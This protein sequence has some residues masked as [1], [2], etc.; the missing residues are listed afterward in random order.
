MEVTIFYSWQSDLPGSTNRSFIEKALKQAIQAIKSENILT[1]ELVMDRDTA[2]V[3]GSPPIADTIFAKIEQAG[4]FVCDVTTINDG[5]PTR[6]TPNPNVLVELGFALKVLGSSRIIMV[7]NL[8]YGSIENLP[9]DLRGRRVVTYDIREEN[10]DKAPKRKSLSNALKG[11]LIESLKTIESERATNGV[12]PEGIDLATQVRNAIEGGQPKAAS[13][14][15]RYM[16]DLVKRIQ[17]LDPKPEG[18]EGDEQL[19][20]AIDESLPLVTEFTSLVEIAVSNDAK[21]ALEAFFQEF[22]KLLQYLRQNRV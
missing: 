9:F 8:A 2:G 17:E 14:A 22:G 19:I 20:K 11:H 4:V 18:E 12:G 5:F 13:L 15:K 6:P 10:P 7:A 21:L 1:L 16:T 3:P